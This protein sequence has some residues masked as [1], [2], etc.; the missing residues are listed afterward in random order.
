M[1]KKYSEH[2]TEQ[3]PNVNDPIRRTYLGMM[4]AM[5]EA[6]GHIISAL[7]TTGKMDKTIIFFASD[8]GGFTVRMFI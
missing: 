5:D 4:T 6:I 7:K 2:P 3:Y 8:N 1:A